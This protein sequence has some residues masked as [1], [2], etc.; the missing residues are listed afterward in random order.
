MPEHRRDR[1][2][3]HP[4]VDRLGRE[5]VAQLVRVDVAETGDHYELT[6]ELPG[7]AK[8]DVTVQVK[9]GLL[10]LTASRPARGPEEGQA[11]E[12][13]WLL[14][15]RRAATFQ[16][17]FRLPRDVNGE[18]IAAAFHDGLLVLTLPKREETKPRVVA[19]QAA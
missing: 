2:E 14:R 8:D 11:E 17:S 18:A 12:R 5:R 9:D 6:A 1:L 7:F 4:T 19:I 10:E 13:R 15:E 3:P 16:R